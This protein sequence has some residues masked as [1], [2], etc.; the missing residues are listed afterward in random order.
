MVGAKALGQP[1]AWIFER[2]GRVPKARV[3]RARGGFLGRVIYATS[4]TLVA[5]AAPSIHWL[6]QLGNTLDLTA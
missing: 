6:L 2:L 3:R 4:L 1:A 5:V